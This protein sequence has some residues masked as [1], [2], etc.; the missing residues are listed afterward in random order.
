MNNNKTTQNSTKIGNIKL[1]IF[2]TISNILILSEV[3]FYSFF[4]PFKHTSWIALLI[5]I[6]ITFILSIIFKGFPND[7]GIIKIIN[8]H[9]I[10]KYLLLIY[11]F[12][13]IS[14]M[15]FLGTIIIK[16]KF[17][18]DVS[19]IIIYA[20]LLFTCIYIGFSNFNNII[21]VSMIFFTL[22]IVFYAI[23]LTHLDGRNLNLLLPFTFDIK[24]IFLGKIILLFPLENIL[25]SLNTDNLRNGFKT[26]AYTIGNLSSMFYLLLI[27]IDS[28]TLLG[29]NYFKN[30]KYGSFIRWEVYQ[31]N[32]FIENY[33]VFVL[34]IMVTTIVFRMGLNINNFQAIMG[35]KKT[36]KFNTIFFIL[37]FIV[38]SVYC[39]FINN[40]QVI[41]KYAI[42]ISFIII[43][44]LYIYFVVL[45][46]IIYIRRKK[47]YGNK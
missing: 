21:N 37:I 42:E 23:S 12:I 35:I 14:T 34:I 1:T 6:G 43:I 41:I 32:K 39:L 3:G 31:G 24:K 18:S 22:I 13:V 44:I 11:Y 26:K 19:I 15:I 20:T 9:F 29:A 10:I 2:M 27:F 17:Y 8:K 4:T 5:Y 46:W 16:D 38:L 33:D 28:L 40:L 45:S 36:N 30:V 25:F 47:I 7:T